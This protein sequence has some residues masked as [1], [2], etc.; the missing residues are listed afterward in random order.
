MKRVL[1]L[2]CAL[3]VAGVAQANLV[4]SEVNHAYSGNFEGWDG[5]ADPPNFTLVN[6]TW[7]GLYDLDGA[8]KHL[9][10]AFAFR[11]SS[12]EPVLGWGVRPEA[13]G[14]A[15]YFN[16][17]LINQTGAAI[18]EIHIF[19]NV[20]QYTKAGRATKMQVY[21]YRIDG[22]PW[23]TGSAAGVDSDIATA[24]ATDPEVRSNLSPV[25]PTPATA[26]IT[27]STLIEDGKQFDIGWR[28]LPGE[29]SGSNAHM[30]F[31]GYAVTVTGTDHTVTPPDQVSGPSEG[32]V[33][34]LLTFTV[35][36]GTCSAGHDLMYTVNWGD[37]T[38]TSWSYETSYEKT[39]DAPGVYP[40]IAEAM[41]P[42]HSVIVS[43]ISP[44]RYV[45]IVDHW[46]ETPARPDGPETGC[47]NESLTF[48]APP[49]HCNQ[50]H[51]VQ[52]QFDWGDGTQS[53][54]GSHMRSTSYETA[55]TYEV[56]VRARCVED[57]TVVS[58]W[59]PARIVTIDHRVST[60]A[61]P[62]G[63][64]EGVVGQWLTYVTAGGVCCGG[65]D[66]EYQFGW[67]DGTQSAWGHAT[68]SNAYD[69]T[70]EYKISAR[71]RCVHDH[72]IQSDWTAHVGVVITEPSVIIV[73]IHVRDVD[74][75][76]E[77]NVHFTGQAGVPYTVQFT[78]DLMA[79]EKGWEDVASMEGTGGEDV[80][81]HKVRTAAGFYRI[82][83]ND[84]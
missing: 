13:T 12:S 5:D 58:E 56:R 77:V 45:Q 67:G 71:V 66:V 35:G 43:D 65:H 46:V 75:G 51:D 36:G 63:P 84:P 50:E 30:G 26:T 32:R 72:T 53:D 68:R 20:A 21:S 47:V 44:V 74:G 7:D 29:G 25:I 15:A 42:I 2:L 49:Q 31:T 54:W 40:V 9:N 82:R 22:G 62:K 14:N 41:C 17:S 48:T 55:G 76:Y 73:A 79:G 81:S 60:P 3:L 80:I 10:R 1:T 38:H 8:Y 78:S 28:V 69:N 70:G 83:E 6:Y 23:Q 11:E 18:S 61:V 37:G 39:Y 4:L 24:S 19:W 52:R 16:L 34:E 59:S 64:G 57:A 27:F 33:G